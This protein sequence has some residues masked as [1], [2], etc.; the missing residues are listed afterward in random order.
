MDSLP[1]WALWAAGAAVGV[2]GLLVGGLLGAL[3]ELRKTKDL[4]WKSWELTGKAQA[5][6]AELRSERDAALEKL[7]ALKAQRGEVLEA[8]I[9]AAKLAQLDALREP[10]HDVRG[11]LPNT[12]PM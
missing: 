4:C 2:I 3:A 7:G 5:R 11:N 8:A 12:G 6:S 10:G 1:D 9:G